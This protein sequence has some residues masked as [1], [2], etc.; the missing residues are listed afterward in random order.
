MIPI[1]I[2]CGCGQRYSFDVEPVNGF[3]PSA[4]ACPICGVDGTSAANELIDR[5]LVAEPEAPPIPISIPKARPSKASV[6]IVAPARIPPPTVSAAAPKAA[7][8]FNMGLGVL[9][10]FLGACIGVGLMYFFYELAGVRFPLLGI[11][12]GVLTGYGA[13]ILFKGNDIALGV[14]SGVI[15][16]LAIVGTLY[17]MYGAFPLMSIISVIVGTSVAYNRASG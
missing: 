1:K 6:G 14:I 7:S 8:E 9:G 11:G 3:M 15:A 2:Q 17:L 13:K 4:V 16:L 5:T 10:A 12:I